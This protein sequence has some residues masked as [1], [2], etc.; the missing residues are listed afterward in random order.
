MTAGGATFAAFPAWYATMFSG[1]YIALLA[2]ALLP[3]HPRDLVRVALEEREPGLAEGVAVG[4]RDRELRRLADLGRRVRE[5]ALRHADQLERRLRRHL[6]GSL[7]RLH[8]ASRV[9]PSSRSSPSTARP[10]SRCERQGDL[11]RA[12]R[13]RRAAAL[14]RRGGARRSLPGLDGRRRSRPQRQERLPAG[15]ARGDRDRR[16]RPR[17]ACSSTCGGRCW[18]FTMTGLG[19]IA[20]GRHALHRASSRG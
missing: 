16:A 19:A 10:S 4:E 6:L 17:R 14:A 13:P 3:D 7:Q 8:R 18:A 15:A 12:R 9:S 11:L 1:L 5:P 2:A 20:R